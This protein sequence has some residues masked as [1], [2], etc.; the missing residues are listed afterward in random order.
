[1]SLKRSIMTRFYLTVTHLHA[2]IKRI[3]KEIQHIFIAD[4]VSTSHLVNS[5]KVLQTYKNK[6][7][8]QDRKQENYDGLALR[9][10]E[11]IP[12]KRW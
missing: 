8:S 9:K 4:S 5:L 2:K 11:R 3:N 10:L 7:N 1:M 12:E 6:K